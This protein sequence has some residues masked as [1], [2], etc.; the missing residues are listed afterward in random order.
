VLVQVARAIKRSI[1]STAEQRGA[2]RIGRRGRRPEVKASTR[3][4]PEFNRGLA[5]LHAAGV[6][7]AAWGVYLGSQP[8][9]VGPIRVLPLQAFLQ[10]L[11]AG[12]VLAAR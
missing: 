9:K 6:I 3:W 7:G 8:L 1:G 5:D 4:R 11:S 10:E 2:P 12:R